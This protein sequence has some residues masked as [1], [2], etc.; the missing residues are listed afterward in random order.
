M[1]LCI[2]VMLLTTCHYV[3]IILLVYEFQLQSILFYFST[4]TYF[5]ASFLILSVFIFFF[6]FFHLIFIV[7]FSFISVT[8]KQF[9]YNSINTVTYSL[10]VRASRM[11]SWCITQ[12]GVFSM[13]TGKSVANIPVLTN[14]HTLELIASLLKHMSDFLRQLVLT[15]VCEGLVAH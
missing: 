14:T 9:E 6:N 11:L 4:Q 2:L 13:S 10:P 3:F 8:Q 15:F 1:G 5:S 12:T 7:F